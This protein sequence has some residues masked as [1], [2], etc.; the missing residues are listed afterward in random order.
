MPRE[1]DSICRYTA[2][3]RFFR[4]WGGTQRVQKYGST[5]IYGM[6][7]GTYLDLRNAFNICCFDPSLGDEVHHF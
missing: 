3:E 7:L 5:A 4:F 2:E 1:G 6:A